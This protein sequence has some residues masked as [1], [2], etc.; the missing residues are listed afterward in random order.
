MNDSK[1][2][3]QIFKNTAFLGSVQVVSALINMV[4]AKV[5]ALILGPAGFGVLNL[6]TSSLA[7]VINFCGFGLNFS[8]IRDL[9]QAKESN[10]KSRLSAVRLVFNRWV[11]LSAIFGALVVVSISGLLSKF[12][13]GSIEHN[14][15]YLILSLYVL[16]ITLNNGFIAYLQGIRELKKMAKANIIGSA[17]GVLVSLPLYYYFGIQG[18]ALGLTFSAL[19]S[20]IVSWKIKRT[21]K[22]PSVE[23][24]WRT[25]FY[26]GAK[27]AKL[28]LLL[29][30][31][32]L[33]GSITIYCINAF[34]QYQGS[35][36]DVGLF[37]AGLSLSNQY[38]GIV[39]AAMA[40]DYFPRLAA[41]HTDNVKIRGL[42]NQQAEIALLVSTPLILILILLMPVAIRILFSADFIVI[43]TFTRLVAVGMIWK[44]ASFSM[45]YIAFAKGDKRV[46]FWL[47]GVYGN[48][49]QLGLNC[50]IYY[51]FGLNGLGIS[52]ILMYILYFG[53]VYFVASKFYSFSFDLVF[54]RIFGLSV[55]LSVILFFVS[56]Y[57]SGWTMILSGFILCVLSIIFSVKELDRRTGFLVK[58]KSYLKR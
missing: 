40:S 17:V 54:W 28:G 11:L 4:R 1:S 34:I 27:M 30:A 6:F 39:L 36:E 31:S 37:Q 45:G 52:F 29:V 49:L 51:Y 12:T 21:V 24:S 14:Q 32:T 38:V 43:S 56:E 18:I 22:L 20:V 55:L 50:G 57:M 3:K 13:F 46:F 44:I 7:T 42:A 25:T 47:E 48:L 53:S 16:L 58:V 15:S 8:A 23:V 9:S 41:V 19:S 26:D 10:D 2:Y 35:V 5:I 33:I